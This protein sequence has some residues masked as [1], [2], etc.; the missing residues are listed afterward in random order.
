MAWKQIL[1]GMSLV[2]FVLV[3][4]IPATHG[5]FIWD[6]DMYVSQNPTL[7]S[8]DGLRRI[9]V[10]PGATPQYYPMVFT[11]FW[12]E[13][14]VWALNPEAF[15]RVNALLHGMNAV[16]L[17]LVLRRLAVPGA[18]FAGALFALHPV[19]V[20]SVA[21]I[22]ERK[23]VLSGFFYGLSM[24]AY[25][26][27]A[28]PD[29]AKPE[30]Q[31]GMGWY[32]LSL[33]LFLCALFSKTVA[34][35]LP[36]VLALILWWKRGK[37]TWKDWLLLLPFFVLGLALSTETVL[38]EKYHVQA[39]GEEWNFGA[40]ERCLIAGRAFWFYLGKLLW[41]A[42]LTFIY[43]R[44]TIDAGAAWQYLFPLAAAAVIVGL[45]LARR[46]LGRGP[47]VAVLFFAGT[48][49][50]ALGFFNIYPQRFSL[51]ADHFQ[52]LASAG[53]LAL[54][55]AA[56]VAAAHRLPGA[57]QWWAV[58]AGGV[59]LL[60][61]GFLTWQQ[62]YVYLNQEVLWTD[63]VTKNPRSWVAHSNVARLLVDQGNLSEAEQHLREAL[64]LHPAPWEAHFG[65]GVV[66][67]MRGDLA[68]AE[69]QFA[70]AVELNPRYVDARTELGSTLIHQGRL[71]EAVQQLRQAATD[72]PGYYGAY[73]HLGT[74]FLLQGR[75]AEAV[76]AY[77]RAAQL[78]AGT[79]DLHYG[80]GI[81]RYSQGDPA[82]AEAEFR[83]AARVDPH[84]P[85]AA[86]DAAWTLATYPDDRVRNG[87]LAV[88]LA[89]KACDA[90]Q[91]SEPVF[92]DTLAAAQAEAGH[93]EQAAATAR[94]AVQSKSALS[95]DLARQIEARL[96]L[97]ERKQP[98]RSTRT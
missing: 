92:L 12:L 54:A 73:Y 2:V 84:W 27:F 60:V 25:L 81:A 19:E 67:Q 75:P 47:L 48:L 78:S 18:W 62:C 20:E 77:T 45:G 5:D 6:D 97:Y 87:I 91:D 35:S 58:G 94:K 86:R 76:V 98:F 10:E 64:T 39:Q 36:A 79:A 80:L 26:R 72:A 3:S 44:W 69:K 57:V 59:L 7:A 55:A 24:L 33:G 37:V 28:L 46:R 17:W 43:P 70:A 52:Y 63:T 13:V 42:R 9:W 88:Q 11:S 85:R 31:G 90:T 56:A 32:F 49:V 16:L 30:Q 68:E 29:S 96:R 15:H 82:A 66:R 23:N 93:F 50:P 21:W 65:I 34:C 51:V 22:T 4:Y 95:P 38:M 61:L 71:A 83:L 14:R 8:M 53:L 41:P 74:A 40:V 1:A 89:Q